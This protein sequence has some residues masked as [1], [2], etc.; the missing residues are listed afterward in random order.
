MPFCRLPCLPLASKGEGGYSH[1]YP[2]RQRPREGKGD[3]F[4]IVTPNRKDIS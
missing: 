2:P 1:S 3:P 4:S